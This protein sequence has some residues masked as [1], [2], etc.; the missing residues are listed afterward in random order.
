MAERVPRE[1]SW[2]VAQLIP[3][4]CVA[5]QTTTFRPAGVTQFVLWLAGSTQATGPAFNS[6]SLSASASVFAERLTVK[7]A[8]F[9]ARMARTF[10]ALPYL[11]V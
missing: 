2:H 7:P 6:A 1:H 4:R 11:C 5:G 10:A 9:A 3:S 8:A